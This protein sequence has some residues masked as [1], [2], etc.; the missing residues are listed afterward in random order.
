[1]EKSLRAPNI[2]VAPLAPFPCP[3]Y[4]WGGGLCFSLGWFIALSHGWNF[5]SDSETQGRSDFIA[6][7]SRRS[8][9]VFYFEQNG[10]NERIS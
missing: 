6:F 3:S 4:P 2:S 5:S 7:Y 9:S 1:M 8:A 10:H